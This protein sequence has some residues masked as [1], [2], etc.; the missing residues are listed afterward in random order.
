MNLLLCERE[1]QIMSSRLC[2]PTKTRERVERASAIHLVE[3]ASRS[4]GDFAEEPALRPTILL[5]EDE[6]FVREVTREV[7]RGAGFSVVAVRSAAEAFRLYQEVGDGMDLL[8]TD[9]ILPGETGPKL[10]ARLRLENPQLHVLYMT[11]YAEQMKRLEARHEAFLAKPF[12][13]ETLL[14]AVRRVLSSGKPDREKYSGLPAPEDRLHHLG[15]N[16]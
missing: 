5:V 1:E 9:V 7:L 3:R 8:F 6:S 13:S 2:H 11:G 15:G 14:E 16:V 10:A 4:A 12:S